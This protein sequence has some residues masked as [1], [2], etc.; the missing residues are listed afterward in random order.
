MEV[1]CAYS[2]VN[3]FISPCIGQLKT[4]STSSDLR[5]LFGMVVYETEHII[6]EMQKWRPRI[7]R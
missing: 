5:I 7:A 1:L 6:S 3:I 4:M 2:Q